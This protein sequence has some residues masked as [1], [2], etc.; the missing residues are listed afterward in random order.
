MLSRQ[1]H[2]KLTDERI[3]RYGSAS[4]E[5][6]LEAATEVPPLR[7]STD[8]TEKKPETT[9]SHTPSPVSKAR[10]SQSPPPSRQTTGVDGN[11]KHSLSDLVDLDMASRN[12]LSV[13]VADPFSELDKELHSIGLAPKGPMVLPDTPTNAD[14]EQTA[15]IGNSVVSANGVTALESPTAMSTID[16][17]QHSVLNQYYKKDLLQDKY[18]K[19]TTD[20][21]WD[22]MNPARQRKGSGDGTGEARVQLRVGRTTDADIAEPKSDLK[23]TKTGCCLI[24]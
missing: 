9:T 18:R 13:N 24:M 10:H 5:D 17:V 6:V 16:A 3:N 7:V 15:V 21:E 8:K 12:S 22:E 2:H 19:S 14:R 11:S 20:L 23:Q 1:S 4:N